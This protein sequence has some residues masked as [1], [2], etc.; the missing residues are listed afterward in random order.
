[1]LNQTAGTIEL[2]VERGSVNASDPNKS[3]DAAEEDKVLTA[4]RGGSK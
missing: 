4:W 1:M 2:G 3:P